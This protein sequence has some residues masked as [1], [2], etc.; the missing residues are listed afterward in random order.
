MRFKLFF[1]VILWASIFIQDTHAQ[2]NNEKKDNLLYK[3]EF[4]I[5]PLIHTSGLGIGYRRA[6]NKT[7]YRKLAWEIEAVTLK[8][9]KEVRSVS[10]YNPTKFI[11]IGK[12]NQCYLLRAGIGQQ[13]LL[14][15]KPYW[16]GVELRYFYMGGLSLAITKPI[17]VKV[18]KYDSGDTTFYYEDEKYDPDKHDITSIFSKSSFFKGFDGLK[19]YPGVYFKTGLNFEFSS[20]SKTLQCLEFGICADLF[21]KNVPILAFRNDQ[22]LFTNLYLS[23]HFGGKRL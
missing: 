10:L 6:Y 4:S 9:P 5:Y 18:V 1:I 12:L 21:Y 15:E 2:E 3:K 7:Y 13:H 8:H 20:G 19:F 23:L 22:F 16:G 11:I 14:N 17:Y